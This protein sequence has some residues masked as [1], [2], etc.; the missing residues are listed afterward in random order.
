MRKFQY[1]RTYWHNHLESS[2]SCDCVQLRRIG[3]TTIDVQPEKFLHENSIE[4]AVHMTLPH[5]MSA[6]WWYCTWNH[7]YLLWCFYSIFFF[8][9]YYFCQRFYLLDYLSLLFIICGWHNC[10]RC[11]RNANKNCCVRYYVLF[12][13]DIGECRPFLF[14]PTKTMSLESLRAHSW[15]IQPAFFFFLLLTLSL[16]VLSA[17]SDICFFR[18][19]FFFLPLFFIAHQ[20]CVLLVA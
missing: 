11:Y 5:S 4:H 15:K 3:I 14:S 16:L 1:A 7:F 20:N 12:P 6:S 13:I 17:I 10:V 8:C 18:L 19:D 9:D 2:S